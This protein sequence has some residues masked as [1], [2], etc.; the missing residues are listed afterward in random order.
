MAMLAHLHLFCIVVAN[1]EHDSVSFLNVDV[2][3]DV[4]LFE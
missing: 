1:T 4:I 3:V 2:D